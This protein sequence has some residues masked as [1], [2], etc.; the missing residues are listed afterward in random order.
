MCARGEPDLA[1]TESSHCAGPRPPPCGMRPWAPAALMHACRHHVSTQWDQCRAARP[2]GSS[3]LGVLRWMAVQPV[4]Q[5]TARKET[6]GGGANESRLSQALELLPK[7]AQ[8]PE[9]EDWSH[10]FMH[11]VCRR[12]TDTYKAASPGTASANTTKSQGAQ[13]AARIRPAGQPLAC[14]HPCY[15]TSQIPSTPL[16]RPPAPV[17]PPLVWLGPAQL[18]NSSARDGPAAPSGPP[19][20][21]AAGPVNSQLTPQSPCCR[22]LQ[23]ACSNGLVAQKEGVLLLRA[24]AE[25]E[26]EMV[27]R[28]VWQQCCL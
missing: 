27:A 22:S 18:S 16:P 26:T 14:P 12:H 11:P 19:L 10:G 23:A 21:T 17:N 1:P 8:P 4:H 13:V 9:E 15:T 6:E 28:F 3:T 20:L 2:P 24:Q 7:R 5:A 25:E